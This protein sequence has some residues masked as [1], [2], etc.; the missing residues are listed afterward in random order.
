MSNGRVH[1][2]LEALRFLYR[3]A[4]YEKVTTWKYNDATFNLDRVERLLEAVDSPHRQFRSVHVAGTK[5]KGSTTAMIGSM[6][7]AA[8]LRVGCFTSPHLVLIE[9]RMTVNGELIPEAEFVE[10]TNRIIPYTEKARERDP[11]T[12]PSFFE[13]ITAIGFLHFAR[14]RVDMAVV[15]VGMGG[16][17]DATNVILPETA[18]I[19]RIDLDHTARLGRSLDRIAFEKGGIIKPGVPVVVGLQ[20]PTALRKLNALAR[21]RRAPRVRVGHDV[22]LLSA[23]SGVTD[24][25]PWCRCSIRGRLG[26]YDDLELR[27]LGAHQAENAATAVAAIEILSERSGVPLDESAI[28]AGLLAA[29]CSGRLEWF[30]GRPPVLLDGAHNPLSARMVR[31]VL[32]GVFAASSITLV[33]GIAADKDVR[34]IVRQ[35]VPRA[36]RVI[37]TRSR[38][39]RALEPDQLA[40]AVRPHARERPL[41]EPDANCALDRARELTKPDDLICVT[42]SFYLAGA[43]RPRLLS[44]DLS[45]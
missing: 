7:Q 3:F 18:V 33:L 10:L 26:S 22:Q 11:Y 44:G 39:V 45:P 40:E 8:G 37:C 6:L 31:S 24:G 20:R 14:Q 34:G 21:E 28:R 23:A 38:H 15:E 25:V 41:I 32:D 5:G 30:A 36:R 29:R 17:L 16:R 43:L 1:T 42:G 27:L 9:E 35:I 4:D 12:S 13:L 19:T 2:I